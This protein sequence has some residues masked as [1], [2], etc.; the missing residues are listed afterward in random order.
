MSCIGGLTVYELWL[1]LWNPILLDI[2]VQHLY[3]SSS[4]FIYVFWLQLLWCFLM[5]IRLCLICVH[6]S[7]ISTQPIGHILD[8]SSKLVLICK[9]GDDE[10]LNQF[11]D[12]NTLALENMID[13]S[14]GTDEEITLMI[15]SKYYTIDSLPVKMSHYVNFNVISGRLRPALH[16]SPIIPAQFMLYQPECAKH[17]CKIWQSTH[18]SGRYSPTECYPSC[19]MYTRN[20]ARWKIYH[21]LSLYQFKGYTCI[22]QGKRCSSHGG[23]ITY[24]DSQFNT[25]M[26]DIKNDSPIW[27]RLFVAVKD[28]ETGKEIVVGNI[29]RPP[30]DDNNEQNV[31]TFLT[32]LEPIIS[33]LNDN[34][35]EL[36]IAGDVDINLP[37]INIC[38]KEHIGQSLDML[39]GYSLF[40][41]IT[42]PT[43]LGENS[44]SLIDNIF[45]S[46]SHNSVASL[47]G[48]ICS[49]ISDHFPCFVSLRL[50]NDG[51]NSQRNKYIKVRVN[52]NEAYEAFLAD[53]QACDFAT[54]LDHTP[55][56]D[57][58]QN[59]DKL[60]DNLSE[61]KCKHLPWKLVK[62]NKYRHKGNRWIIHG[63][64][65]FGDKLYRNLIGAQ[66]DSLFYAELINILCVYNKILK[67]TI[68][69]AKYIYYNRQFEESQM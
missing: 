65:K 1:L 62:F 69:E 16:C 18:I 44:C 43:R 7:C 10:T 6:V 5:Y 60:H 25:S 2:H 33:T 14:D 12:I 24:V 27:E 59:Y 35:H 57:S 30:Y 28:I 17:Q 42:F 56:G 52:S 40:P 64:I 39:L 31:T 34:N 8:W 50:R 46:L 37:H 55:H 13:P 41:K 61:L 45:C 51:T 53:L 21:D 20:L 11:A 66:K 58:N 19:H 15:P 29:Y 63:V 36:L 54:L 9:Y 22:S 4:V 32:E 48:I 49:K 26:M 3:F 47:T 67:K 23:L 68:P 38:N